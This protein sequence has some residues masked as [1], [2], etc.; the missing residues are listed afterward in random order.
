MHGNPR[1]LTRVFQETC[2]TVINSHR[3]FEHAQSWW[4]RSRVDKESPRFNESWYESLNKLVKLSSTLIEILNMFKVD[5]SARESV[6]FNECWYE[7]FNK[8][9]KLTSTFIEIFNVFKVDEITRE[10]VKLD[11]NWQESLDKRVKLSSTLIEILSMLKL[12]ENA[13]Q[14][15]RVDKINKSQSTNVWNCHKHVQNWGC[16]VDETGECTRVGGTTCPIA[17]GPAEYNTQQKF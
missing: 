1:Q 3:N 5:E 12:G 17:C 9:V 2:E 10:S 13:R 15:T 8:R 4:E 16:T 14:S 6:R 11:E 7:S